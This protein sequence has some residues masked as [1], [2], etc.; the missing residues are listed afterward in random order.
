MVLYH[1]RYFVVTA[2]PRAP[3]MQYFQLQMP[4]WCM[5]MA[6]ERN[7]LGGRALGFPLGYV[8]MFALRNTQEVEIVEMIAR[9]AARYVLEGKKVK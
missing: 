2:P 3:R 4:R 5:E 8:I 9:A 1:E 6:G 7:G